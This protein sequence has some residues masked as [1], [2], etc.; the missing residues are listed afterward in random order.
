MFLPILDKEA[1]KAVMVTTY[2][3][4]ILLVNQHEISSL[5]FLNLAG[6]NWPHLIAFLSG[7]MSFWNLVKLILHWKREQ[8]LMT[9]RPRRYHF[10]S[11]LVLPKNKLK[12]QKFINKCLQLEK[13][14]KYLL[15]LYFM[16]RPLHLLQVSSKSK[17]FSLSY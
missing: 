9:S 7:T 14:K 12:N 10:S 2:C 17:K 5:L 6:I 4:L 1:L 3:N 8:C 16:L 15:L 11:Y 13:K